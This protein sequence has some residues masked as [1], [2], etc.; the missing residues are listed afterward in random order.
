M[1]SKFPNFW[2]GSRCSSIELEANMIRIVAGYTSSL[3]FDS[4]QPCDF[5]GVSAFKVGRED[6]AV[7]L[8]LGVEIESHIS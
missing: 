7:R 5:C 8:I 2:K 1:W 3:G 4:F 6:L